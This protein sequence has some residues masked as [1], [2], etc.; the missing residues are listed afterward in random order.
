MSQWVSEWQGHLLSCSGQIKTQRNIKQFTE[1]Y[2][3]FFK[4][5]D[6]DNYGDDDNDADDDE[7]DD[8]ENDDEDKG[9]LGLGWTVGGSASCHWL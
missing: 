4:K 7:A 9:C 1:K 2:F 6:N 5:N 3:F 8:D